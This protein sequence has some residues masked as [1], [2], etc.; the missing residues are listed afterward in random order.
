MLGAPHEYTIQIL[1]HHLD[2]FGHVNNA[3]YLELLEEARWDWITHGG[4]SLARVQETRKGP[5]ILECTLRF[6]RELRLREQIRIES[7]IESYERKI[8]LVTQ[9][10]KT[11]D[12]KLA[13][14]ASFKV[15]LFD[16]SE[17]R[18][19]APTAEWL[20]AFGLTPEMLSP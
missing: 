10:I 20:A 8:A 2:T 16:L 14:E 7:W 11:P 19:I 13:C 12:G 18:L 4:Y 17:R 15:G 3:V 5:T 6:A 1:E 9:V